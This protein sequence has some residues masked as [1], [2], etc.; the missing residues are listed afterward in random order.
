MDRNEDYQRKIFVAHCEKEGTFKGEEVASIVLRIVKKYI[1]G[2]VLDVGA[3][4][5]ALIKLLK[6]RGLS[7][8]GIDLYSASEDVLEGTITNLPFTNECFNTIFCCDVIEH[9]NKEQLSK[10]L[11]EIF[12]VLKKDGHFILTTPYNENIELQEVSCPKCGHKF[13]RYGHLQSFDEVRL[14]E[15]CKAHGFIIR[16]M[17]I[18]ALGGMEKLPLGRFFNFILKR[19]DFEFVEKTIIG[20][21]M[22]Q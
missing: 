8:K 21:W 2:K 10:G 14:R 5:G 22:R 4:S 12:R 20:V 19:L 13:H 17:R 11:R 1:T 18:Y 16:L 3:G 15:I 7:A 6:K 9:L